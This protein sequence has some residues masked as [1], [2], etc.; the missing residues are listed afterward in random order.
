LS[1]LLLSRERSNPE[2]RSSSRQIAEPSR[3]RVPLLSLPASVHA[4]DLRIWERH[5]MRGKAKLFTTLALA[6]ACGTLVLPGMASA[7]PSG[8]T[9]HLDRGGTF[10]GFV[11]SPKPGA[12]ADGRTVKLFRKL[13]KGKHPKR[14]NKVAETQAQSYSHG[15][16]KWAVVPSRPHPGAFYA[17]VPAN[18]TCQGDNSK[19]LHIS[20]RPNT[21]ITGMSVTHGRNVIFKYRGLHGLP[22][23]NFQCKLDAKP[24]RH[25]PDLE[26]RYVGLSRGHHLFKVRARNDLGKQDRTPARRGFRI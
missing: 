1:R 10:K 9:L 12:C 11:F 6:G 16:F 7:A 13:G 2:F 25:C 14:D 5:G 22:P 17:R 26:R 4:A 23:Y 20:E 18:P 19:T 21:K 15:R 24:Y 3:A 8:V